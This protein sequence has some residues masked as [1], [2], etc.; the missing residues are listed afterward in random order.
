MVWLA[1]HC[2]TTISSKNSDQEMDPH[3]SS[4]D[5]CQWQYQD[6]ATSFGF[7]MMLTT[8]RPA[9]KCSLGNQRYGRFVWNTRG[10]VRLSNDE[11]SSMISRN[12]CSFVRGWYS[13]LPLRSM[14][15][16]SQTQ[17]E[18]VETCKVSDNSVQW[19]KVYNDQ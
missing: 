11:R 14:V 9:L 3:P 5:E 10:A 8:L 19:T 18:P 7:L 15:M 17:C 4:L 1:V 13:A 12:K 2:P 6:T 16:I